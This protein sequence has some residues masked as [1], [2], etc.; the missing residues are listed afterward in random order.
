MEGSDGTPLTLE[1]VKSSDID[2]T[3]T[4]PLNITPEG[5]TVRPSLLKS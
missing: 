5:R 2:P 4:C 1:G 3:H